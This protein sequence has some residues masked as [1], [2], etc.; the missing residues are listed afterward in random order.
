MTTANRI[1]VVVLAFACATLAWE[2][3]TRDKAAIADEPDGA[4]ADKREANAA[5]IVVADQGDKAAS[6]A[7]A[8][9]AGG[10]AGYIDAVSDRF[11]AALEKQNLP[12]VTPVE[13]AALR[14]ELHRYLQRR[15]KTALVG[16]ARAELLAAIDKFVEIKFSG[17]TSYVSF[18]T[19][20]N[21]LSWQLWTATE[22]PELTADALRERDRQ[23][24]WMVAYIRGLPITKVEQ[25]APQWQPEARL[26]RWNGAFSATRSARS[27]TTRC[28]PRNSRRLRGK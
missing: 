28:R 5:P 26:R 13:L 23:R 18:R 1:F 17:P 15:V 14:G 7:A 3:A 11:V 20:F 9:A 27:S 19:N 22:R 25:D 10:V 8:D 24:E 6:A 2:C 4:P 21:S 12:Y 16:P